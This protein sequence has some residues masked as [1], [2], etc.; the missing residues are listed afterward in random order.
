MRVRVQ[1]FL[2]DPDKILSMKERFNE[3]LALF[4]V[5]S[6]LASVCLMKNDTSDVA[7]R[8]H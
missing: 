1:T 2:N 8:Q 4:H 5:R 7:E 6:P 3:A